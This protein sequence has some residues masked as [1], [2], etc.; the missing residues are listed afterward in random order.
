MIFRSPLCPGRGPFGRKFTVAVS[1]TGSDFVGLAGGIG[2]GADRLAI[3][4][5]QGFRGPTRLAD[6]PDQKSNDRCAASGGPTRTP[7]SSSMRIFVV[8]PPG[9]ENPPILPPA[10]RTR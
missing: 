6:A 2:S 10:A 3:I 9:A 5:V 7:S 8:D 1:P 4:R